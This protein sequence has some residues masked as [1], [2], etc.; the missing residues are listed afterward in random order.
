MNG[1]L[2]EVVCAKKGG[3][4][5]IFDCNVV[6]LELVPR[7]IVTRPSSTDHISH[8]KLLRVETGLAADTKP[9]LFDSGQNRY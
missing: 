3:E 6:C 7:P 5:L 9:V 2:G 1:G 8:D 4:I